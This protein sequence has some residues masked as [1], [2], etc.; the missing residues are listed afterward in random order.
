[1]TVSEPPLRTRPDV[2]GASD[3]YG[4]DCGGCDAHLVVVDVV[5]DDVY[6]DVAVQPQP[7][8]DGHQRRHRRRHYQ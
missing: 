1:M 4:V 7:Q 3:N 2:V 6:D 8:C 5:V